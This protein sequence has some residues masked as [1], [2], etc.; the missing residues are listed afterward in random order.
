L[1]LT[2]L[3]SIDSLSA[4]AASEFGSDPSTD[5]S[6]AHSLRKTREESLSHVGRKLALDFNRPAL[7]EDEVL[8]IALSG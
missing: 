1:R 8:S 7:I 5:L 2:D 4:I 6:G 3:R